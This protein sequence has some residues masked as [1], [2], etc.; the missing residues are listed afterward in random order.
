MRIVSPHIRM[1]VCLACMA[2]GASAQSVRVNWQSTAPFS[3]YKTYAWH[4]SPHE[5]SSF[6]NQ[7]VV[8]DMDSELGKKGLHKVPAS[9]HPNLLV[10][11]HFKTQ[12][13]MDSTT[14]EDGFG[15]GGG[16]WRYWGGWGGWGMDPDVATTSEEPR[17][18][19]I[20][21]VDLVDAGK[22]TVVWRGQ[23]TEDNVSNTQKGDEKQ[24]RK[25]VEKMLAKYPPKG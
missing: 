21:T 5:K 6:Y 14:T 2:L 15:W 10:V 25:S 19:G 12:E 9:Q 22:K 13:V 24:V 20:L 11:Y 3:D 1:M 16:G 17:A 7:F 8:S 23:A 4:L 18:M